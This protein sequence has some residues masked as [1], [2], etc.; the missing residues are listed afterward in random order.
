MLT[1]SRS[2]RSM[3]TFVLIRSEMS[4]SICMYLT[5]DWRLRL[6]VPFGAGSSESSSMSYSSLSPSPLSPPLMFRPS[7]CSAASVEDDLKFWRKSTKAAAGICKSLCPH[8][9]VDIHTFLLLIVDER[10]LS[11][12]R[13]YFSEI[14]ISMSEGGSGRLY[15]EQLR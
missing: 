1:A 4:C 2:L 14:G 6:C 9:A 15:A 13:H 10:S 7:S 3:I 11:K 8:L 12:K 5:L